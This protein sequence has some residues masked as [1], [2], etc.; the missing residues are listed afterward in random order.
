MAEKFLLVGQKA[1]LPAVRDAN[2][3]YWVSDTREL[4]KGN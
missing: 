1:N 4:Y 2:K 3:L